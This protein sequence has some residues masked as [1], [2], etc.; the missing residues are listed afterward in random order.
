MPS[1]KEIQGSL[2][3]VLASASPRRRVLLEGAGFRV[4]VRPANVDEAARAHETP[5]AYAARVAL[6]KVRAGVAS[7]SAEDPAWVLASDTVVALDDLIL[8]KPDGATTAAETLARLSG[9][10]HCVHTAVA[11]ASGRG[12]ETVE[13]HTAR[14]G[15]RPLS[16]SEIDAY[17]ATG[18]A[19]DKAGA[20]GI[21][22]RAGAFVESVEGP[23]DAVVG[24]PVVEVCALGA[25]LGAWGVEA[26]SV[27]RLRGLRGRIAAACAAVDRNP[28]E[29]TLI[30]VSKFHAPSEVE[31]LLDAGLQDFGENYVQAW[32]EKANA[33]EA[34]APRWHFIG[35]LQSNK[36]KFV[37]GAVALVH[38]VDALS[39]AEALARTTEQ[40]RLVQPV[41]V[42]VNLSGEVQKGGLRVDEVPA[43]LDHVERLGSLRVE[44]LMTMPPD[45]ALHA[46]RAV[47]GALRRVRDTWATPARPLAQLS[48][49][50]SGD[51][52]QAIAE[53]ST[54]V[55]V[56]TALFGPRSTS[57]P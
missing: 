4:V 54:M 5:V 13:V 43:F 2:E 3:V 8:G 57:E 55:R 14:V 27:V 9:R 26:P 18:E 22:G 49:G 28:G 39:T 46:S 48:M 7:R 29:V 47:F 36:A 1:V 40:R 11:M 33:L 52:D 17:V 12:V 30:G 45:G 42:Q 38:T 35:R 19:F 34:R 25:R 20:Y 44:G 53:G 15:F 32:R 56:G 31:T 21:Q 37:A 24:L 10:T 50:M 23:Y 51:F 6:D 41:L 16:P